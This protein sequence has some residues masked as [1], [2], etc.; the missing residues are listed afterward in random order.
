[1]IYVLFITVLVLAILNFI[2]QRRDILSPSFWACVMFE[3]SILVNILN[4]DRWGTSYSWKALIMIILGLSMLMM[5]EV[6]SKQFRIKEKPREIQNRTDKIDNP[7]FINSATMFVL[8]CISLACL[9]IDIRI[10]TRITGSR[11]VFSALFSARNVLTTGEIKRGFWGRFA[12]SVNKGIAFVLIYIVLYN[13]VLC[14]TK[15]KKSCLIPIALFCIEAILSTGRTLFIRIIAYSFIIFVL[16]YISK[17]G[18]KIQQ[19]NRI[20]LIGIGALGV[21]IVI[22]TLLG[23][24]IG[25]GQYDAALDV[26]YYY[27]GSSINLFNKYIIQVGRPDS[28]YFGE[29]TLYGI[30]NIL[31]YIIPG[32]EHNSNPALET[33]Y[34]PHWYSNIYTAFR[35][36]YQDFGMLGM[37][38]IPFCLGVFY[39][40]LEMNAKTHLSNKWSAIIYAYAIYPI[41]EIA[42]EERFLVNFL[43]FSTVFELVVLYIMFKI[44]T[45]IR[46]TIRVH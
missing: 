7:I 32:I 15:I 42:I 27:S 22:F 2:T 18:T 39:G 4:V 13:G 16:F 37:I 9:L 12:L 36:Y 10:M 28:A 35:R 38:I 5:G 45:R 23:K 17:N 26:L 14:Q 30:Y 1:M 34:L 40:R 31:H 11:N 20:V 6:C 46:F 25:K 44:V 8:I 33:M 43:S 3:I 29:H 21:F 19:L 41:I 24:L